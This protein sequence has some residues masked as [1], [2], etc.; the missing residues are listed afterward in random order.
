MGYSGLMCPLVTDQWQWWWLV[1]WYVHVG[2]RL[3]VW[4]WSILFW[5]L[6]LLLFWVCLCIW[7]FERMWSC[8][9]LWIFCVYVS[10]EKL[11]VYGFAGDWVGYCVMGLFI[12]FTY[13]L[14]WF[15]LF[16]SCFLDL[17]E[18]KFG[19]WIWILVLLEIGF[20]VGFISWI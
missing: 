2:F 5:S 13:G 19:C 6:G 7:F 10:Q 18:I 20:V 9:F 12:Q 16:I 3:V 8:L 1:V 17:M 15:L 11:W 4:L 14:V